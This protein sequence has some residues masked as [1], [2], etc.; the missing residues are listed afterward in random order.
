MKRTNSSGV[1]N[2]SN[3]LHVHSLTPEKCRFADP[4]LQACTLFANHAHTAK[5]GAAQASA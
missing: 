1:S 2:F 5:A 3:I 4:G